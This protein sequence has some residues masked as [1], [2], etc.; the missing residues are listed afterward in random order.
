MSSENQRLHL[1]RTLKDGGGNGTVW[2]CFATSEPG[3][4]ANRELTMNLLLYQLVLEKNVQPSANRLRRGPSYRIMI[5]NIQVNP[6]G[7]GS[8]FFQIQNHI[9]PTDEKCNN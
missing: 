3:Q 6:P 2:G 5:P 4:L 7:N 9:V 8:T 1:I